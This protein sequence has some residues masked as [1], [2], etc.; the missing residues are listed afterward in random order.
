VGHSVPESV[1]AGMVFLETGADLV[2]DCFQFVY[3]QPRSGQVA[4]RTEQLVA[5]C[6]FAAAKGAEQVTHNGNHGQG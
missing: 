2:E 4:P 1:E 5:V 3:R 6:P